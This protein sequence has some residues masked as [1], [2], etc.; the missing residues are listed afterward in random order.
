MTVN[1]K[2]RISKRTELTHSLFD[3]ENQHDY[4]V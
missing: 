3:I 2:Y 4:I 1:N